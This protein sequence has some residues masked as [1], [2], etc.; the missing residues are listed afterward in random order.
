MKFLYDTIYV[1]FAFSLLMLILT[2]SC[3]QYDAENESEGEVINSLR[4]IR[5]GEGRR[6]LGKQ[7]TYM[8][9]NKVNQVRRRW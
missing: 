8:K 4:D 3:E 1:L 2:T 7:D 6:T 9:R 5:G